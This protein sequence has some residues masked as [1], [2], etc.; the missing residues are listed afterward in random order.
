VRFGQLDDVDILVT[1][2]TPDSALAQRLDESGVEVWL[3]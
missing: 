2:E 1:D 3:A